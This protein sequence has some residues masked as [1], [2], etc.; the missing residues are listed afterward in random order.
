[1]F[2]VHGNVAGTGDEATLGKGSHGSGRIV[3][4]DG[5]VIVENST[6]KKTTVNEETNERCEVDFVKATIDPSKATALY[7]EES[8]KDRFFMSSWWKQG[9]EDFVQ[10]FSEDVRKI[11]VFGSVEDLVEVITTR[12][13]IKEGLPP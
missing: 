11:P 5:V 13:Q 7:A 4:P 1:M 10:E 3:G 6:E 9:A 8:I 2:V 12:E